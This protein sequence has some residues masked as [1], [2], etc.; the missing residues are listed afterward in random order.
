MKIRRIAF[1][2]ILSVVCLTGVNAQEPVSKPLR[3]TL[4]IK[5]KELCVGQPFTIS[6][7]LENVSKTEQLLDERK[8]WRSYFIWGT[9]E[10]KDKNKKDNNKPEEFSDLLSNL[11]KIK[12]GM[13]VVKRE[14]WNLIRLKPGDFYEDRI[15]FTASDNFFEVP[16]T[17]T[18][19]VDY[20]QPSEK[21]PND[22]SS[23]EG[24]VGSGELE[25]ILKDCN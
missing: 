7:R 19:M 14:N 5:E 21:P 15:V 17:Y 8:L 3:L 24:I 20:L 12:G 23:S 1:F 2:I 18:Y 11:T 13:S 9:I 10:S 22:A 16:G 6:V 4:R 25:L